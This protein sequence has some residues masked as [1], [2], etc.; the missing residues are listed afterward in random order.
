[1]YGSSVTLMLHA[2]QQRGSKNVR[3]G[4]ATLRTK[5]RGIHFINHIFD[6][7]S[8]GVKWQ[9]SIRLIIIVYPVIFLSP[10]L[11]AAYVHSVGLL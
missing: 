11:S 9:R 8:V 7:D 1:M 6:G 2:L 5:K 10:V 3:L 4:F